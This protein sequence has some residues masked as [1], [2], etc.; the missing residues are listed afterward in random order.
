MKLLFA[1]HNRNKVEELKNIFPN[2]YSLM[3]LNELND[4][5]EIEET[6]ANLHENALLKA[7]TI[8]EKY[9]VNTISDDTG[10]EIVALNGAPGVLSARFAG[11][12]NDS[13][14]NMQKVLDLMQN[15]TNRSAQFKTVI[16][17]ILNG[18]EHL[19]E[20]VVKGSILTHLKGANGFGYDPIFVPDG[21]D[22]T[23]A[24]MS[25]EIKNKISHR[26]I[27]VNNL[28]HFLKSLPQ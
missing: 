6:G 26:A 19:F 5:D 16:V 7:R 25:A 12:E 11:E 4:H 28:L 18:K 2:N 23:F 10:L 3:G 21:Y 20:G 22:Q 14:K 15:E 27:A 1:S 17:L 24:E 9:G 8:Y 13:L